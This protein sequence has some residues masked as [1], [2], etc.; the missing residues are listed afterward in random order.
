M[1]NFAGWSFA[2]NA[3][4]SEVANIQWRLYQVTLNWRW[5]NLDVRDCLRGLSWPLA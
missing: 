5:R 2:V 1:S 4:A 3:I